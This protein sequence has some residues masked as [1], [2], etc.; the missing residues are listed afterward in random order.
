M[1]ARLFATLD[2]YA[3]EGGYDVE[4]GPTT[5]YAPTHAL[6]RTTAPGLA[7]GLWD[8]YEEVVERAAE[9]GLDG[10]RLGVEWARV[11]PRRDEVDGA[12]LERYARVAGAARAAGLA[13]TVLLFDEVWPLWAGLEAWL[14]PWVAPYALAHGRRVAERIDAATGIVVASDPRGLV[15][16]G[17]VTGAAPPWRREARADAR[18]A[19]DQVRGVVEALESDPAIAPRRASGRAVSLETPPRELADLAREGGD[20]YLRSLVAGSGPTGSRTGLLVRRADAW[21]P[22]PAAAL[23][24]ALR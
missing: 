22:G 9:L 24:A 19:H 3:V 18:D 15:D 13:V 5:C 14:L 6:R 17:F 21:V 1:S 11:E 12:A 10:I 4:G 23:L 16:R 20:L 8:D 2:G 7:A